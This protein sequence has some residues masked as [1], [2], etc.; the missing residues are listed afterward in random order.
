VIN[1]LYTKICITET[2]NTLISEGG[3]FYVGGLTSVDIRIDHNKE[4]Q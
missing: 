4:L 2:S 1:T 3:S